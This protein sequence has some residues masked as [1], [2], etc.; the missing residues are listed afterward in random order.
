MFQPQEIKIAS[1]TAVSDEVRLALLNGQLAYAAAHSPAYRTL[2]PPGPLQSLSELSRLPLMD[3]DT[4][5]REERRLVCVSAD[6]VARI[7]S[8]FTSGSTG[9]A[10]RLYF[11]EN[12]L[13]RTV[14]FFAEGMAWM[15]GAGDTVAVLMPCTAPDGIGDLLCRGLER[16]GV[17][18]LPIGIPE[19][20][21]AV[22]DLLQREQP[23][24]LVGFP[25]HVRL[26][27]L[28]CPGLRPRAVLLSGDYIPPAL[29]ALISRQWE[30]RVLTHFGMTE[31][32]Y[33]CA[34]QHPCAE[35]M[36]LRRDEFVAEIIDPVGLQPLPAGAVGEL[37]LSSLR[38]E[39]MPLLRYRTGDLARLTP[40]GN[41]GEILGRCRLPREF[42]RLQ[43][44]L[45]A[46]PWLWDYQYTED[47]LAAAVHPA[48]PADAAGEL[49]DIAGMQVCT[50]MIPTEAAACFHRGKRIPAGE[51]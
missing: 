16:I 22:S 41:I 17:R 5:R 15:C 34:V 35:E 20:Y 3:A 50:R 19:D 2:L 14:D 42:Y 6:R 1:F 39:A 38:R 40:E 32:G 24:V 25:W 9:T 12:D 47:G 21:A 46:L 43:N 7:V 29:S 33:G 8:L 13:A 23:Q 48:A 45:S 27:A 26:L 10:K 51:L 49:S 37:V 44:E 11:T 18:P 30:T 31:T 28:R 36:F 4:L